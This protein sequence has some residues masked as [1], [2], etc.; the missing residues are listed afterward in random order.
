[1][2]ISLVPFASGM[3]TTGALAAAVWT[4]RG[5]GMLGASVLGLRRRAGL[6]LRQQ[7]GPS[8]PALLGIAVMAAV[9]GLGLMPALAHLGSLAR[10]LLGAAAGAAVYVATV[11]LVSPRLLPAMAGFMASA[12]RRGKPAPVAPVEVPIETTSRA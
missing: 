12:A 9:L 3:V 2:L 10:V 8:G 1:L 6:T 11:A 7:L 5:A 4:A